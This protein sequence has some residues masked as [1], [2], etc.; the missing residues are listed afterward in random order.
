MT[1]SRSRAEAEQSNTI[2]F[3]ASKDEKF[4]FHKGYKN[5]LKRLRLK[6]GGNKE[7]IDDSKL[8]HCRVFVTADPQKPFSANE[9]EALASYFGRGGSVLIMSGEGGD[10]ASRANLNALTEDL[11]I[12]IND[13]VVV[14]TQ[15]FKYFHPKECFV[16]NGVL[17]RGLLTGGGD[18][19]GLETQNHHQPVD[20]TLNF[21]YPHGATLNVKD[22]AIPV[23]SSGAVSFPLSRPVAAFFKH[24]D[25]GGKVAVVGSAMMFAD[26]YV[27]KEDNF[28]IFQL[29]HKFLTS[30]EMTLNTLDAEDPEITDYNFI[31]DSRAL[32]EQLKVC[33]QEGEELSPDHNEW[34]DTKL[35]SFDFECLPKVV[36]V[37]MI[38]DS[39][40]L[41]R[42]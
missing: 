41:G 11:G 35:F 17:N 36:R 19:G 38:R 15:F 22:P 32:S 14:R 3:N 28:K 7:V 21:V 23:L 12:T 13:D 4:H 1:S 34:L 2:I 16:S 37:S 6:C 33:L 9:I 5:L 30:E 24:P 20:Q 29:I 40:A 27:D 25:S 10:S 42:F 31:P 18:A 39:G 26:A 8:R